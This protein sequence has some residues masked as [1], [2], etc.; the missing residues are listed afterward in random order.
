MISRAAAENCSS[1]GRS[2]NAVLSPLR[3]PSVGTDG[4]GDGGDGADGDATDGEAT[5]GDATVGDA[6]A[7]RGAAASI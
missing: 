3:E 1:E 5:G 2:P 6:A 7:S 4:D